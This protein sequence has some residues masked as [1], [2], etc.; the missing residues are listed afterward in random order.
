MRPQMVAMH[1]D[2]LVR[3]FIDKGEAQHYRLA[4]RKHLEAEHGHRQAAKLLERELASALRYV[5]YSRAICGIAEKLRTRGSGGLRILPG[6][7][8]VI[9]GVTANEIAAEM[10]A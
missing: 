4:L 6:G 10:R 5:A 8:V 2:E 7:D 1:E 9:L 3:L